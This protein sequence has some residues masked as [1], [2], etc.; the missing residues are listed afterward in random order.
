VCHGRGAALITAWLSGRPTTGPEAPAEVGT[1]VE[2]HRREVHVD[3][4]PLLGSIEEAE[5]LLQEALLRA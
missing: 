3:C 2:P 1:R 4:Y 5:D